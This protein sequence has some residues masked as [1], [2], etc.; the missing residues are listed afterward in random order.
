MIRS[1]TALLFFVPAMALAADDPI[2]AELDKARAQYTAGLDAAKAKLVGAMDAK[3]KEVA[4]NGDLDK[5]KEVKSQK[6]LFEKDGTIPK[7]SLLADARR[8]YESEARV[9]R[10]ALYKAIE[11]AK[12][13][14]TKALKLN[15]AEALAAELKALANANGVADNTSE[16]LNA[17]FATASVWKGTVKEKKG[18]NE[19]TTDVVVTVSKREGPAF[20]GTYEVFDGKFIYRIEGSVVKDQVSFKFTKIEKP[21][22]TGRN[23]LT[24]LEHKGYITLDPK[25]KKP[26]LVTTYTWR[27]MNNPNLVA[28][29]KVTLTLGD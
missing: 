13:E 26:T 16:D 12:S 14:Y 15:E 11:K 19:L 17:K 3:L 24:G 9:A 28:R 22:D 8:G 29:G 1:L 4:G 5:A 25:T 7:T 2:K 21:K 27:D 6:E 18:N 23:N 20:E 10:E